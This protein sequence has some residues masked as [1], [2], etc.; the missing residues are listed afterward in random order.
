MMAGNLSV[1]EMGRHTGLHLSWE[2]LRDQNELER[3]DWNQCLKGMHDHSHLPFP[4]N[5]AHGLTAPPLFPGPKPHFPGSVTLNGVIFFS[6][7]KVLLSQQ[8]GAYRVK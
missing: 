4:A 8:A 1:L 2:L 6:T 3:G 5:P 7:S